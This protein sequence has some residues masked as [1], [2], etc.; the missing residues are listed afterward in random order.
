MGRLPQGPPRT[1]HAA[2]AAL[3]RLLA[4][5]LCQRRSDLATAQITRPVWVVWLPPKPGQQTGV[6]LG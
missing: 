1:R 5:L 4:P 2:A 6:V 3:R